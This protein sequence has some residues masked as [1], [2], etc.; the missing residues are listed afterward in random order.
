MSKLPRIS[1]RECEGIMYIMN[2]AP[3]VKPIQIRRLYRY[4]RIGIYDDILIHDVGWELFAR[5]SDIATVAD[6]YR[7]GHVPC[8]LCHTKI[9][10]KIDPLFSS[11]EGGTRED[12]FHCPHCTKRLLWRDCRVKLRETP[13]CFSCYNILKIT[14]N[15]QCSCGKSWTQQA[16]NQ[17]VRTRVRLPCPHCHNLV[18]DLQHQNMLGGS[19]FVRLIQN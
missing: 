7:E 17:S 11:G 3:R 8:P 13:R 1:G 2:W 19:K 9:T 10:R 15:L 14:D 5:C 6:V 18:R 16:Y 12:W 4:A